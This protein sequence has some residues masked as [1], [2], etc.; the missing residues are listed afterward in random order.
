[1]ESR[2]QTTSVMARLMGLDK[3]PPPHSIGEKQ[4]VLSEKYLQK[5]ATIGL[6][7]KRPSHQHN[8]LTMNIE[9]K[10]EFWEVLERSKKTQKNENHKLTTENGMVS[11]GSLETGNLQLLQKISCGP[12]RDFDGETGFYEALWLP[13][14]QL[15]SR[16]GTFPST[17]IVLKP[18][19]RK[20]ESSLK[21]FSLPSSCENCHLGNG[22]LR[23]FSS[24]KIAT[25][26]PGMK[27]R[28]KLAG[29][30][31]SIK[32]N[33]RAFRK[34]SEEVSTGDGTK[35]VLDRVSV[36]L[37]RGN[38][39]SGGNSEMIGPVR[40]DDPRTRTKNGI[41]KKDWRLRQPLN[42]YSNSSP[43]DSK[44]QNLNKEDCLKHLNLRSIS[45]KSKSR[46]FIS[47][48]KLKKNF[49]EN[50]LSDQNPLISKL[51]ISLP[52]LTCGDNQ[53][54]QQKCLMKDE[55]KSNKLQQRAISEQNT[56]SPNSTINGQVA[57]EKSEVVKRPCGNPNSQLSESTSCILFGESDFS[58]HASYTSIQQVFGLIQNY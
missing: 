42:A 18:N 7:R 46:L 25:I 57:D 24:P 13:K 29:H 58:S 31:E 45:E 11:P 10:E 51:S 22:Q 54:I 1:M 47:L 37:F 9:E 6:R 38:E 15:E 17:S 28:Q 19:A 55:V 4:R 56:A 48:D 41:L 20:V 12:P 34:V 39:T 49:Y 30:V 43:H 40:N 33:P 27:E 52:S 35:R 53:N 32:Q 50:D 5:V 14:S 2:H 26:Y 8:S 36:S 16:D 3:E 44:K 21:C 23:D